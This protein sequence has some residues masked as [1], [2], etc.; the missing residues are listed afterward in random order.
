[1]KTTS[2][3][4]SYQDF[5]SGDYANKKFIFRLLKKNAASSIV[6][7]RNNPI[8]YVGT[9]QIPNTSIINEKNDKGNMIQKT[10]RW[11][12][13]ES[14][15]YQEFQTPAKDLVKKSHKIAFTNGRKVVD[16]TDIFLLE[17]LMKCNQNITNINRKTSVSPVFELVDNTIAVSKEI[18]K[19]KLISE[20]T[21][22]C[23]NGPWDEVAAYARVL[24]IPMNQ[25]VDEVRHNLK[26][27]AMRDTE[28]FMKELKNP[29]MR[30][31]HYVLE[32]LD[33]N[34]LTLDPAS[35]TIAWTNNPY[36]PVAVAPAGI[37]PIDVLVRKLS[38]DEGQL[39]YSTIVD[40]LTPEPIVKTKMSIPSKAELAEMKQ[41][42]VV[43]EEP[44]SAVTE[45]DAELMDIV[46]EAV[47]LKI[48]AVKNNMW[49]SYKDE[50]FKKKEGFVEGLKDNPA[51]LKSLRYEIDK[52]NKAV[53]V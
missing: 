40:L 3:K 10:I 9:F 20:V 26:I 4:G 21:N 22:W 46:V 52:A 18:A 32:A 28:K 39:M 12:P 47:K 6:D 2:E 24:N 17:F 8:V 37:S 44:V 5:L 36:E 19:D 13:G 25:T 1:M 49:H 45:S 38:T 43:V 34:Y 27:V 29:E 53:T 35:N 33:R 30:K 41:S 23:W 51:M 31:K 14:T 11:I 48:V 42:K 16:G 50:N 15:I 7:A